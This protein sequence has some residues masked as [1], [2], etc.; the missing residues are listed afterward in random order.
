MT[1]S[2]P[3]AAKFSYELEKGPVW[4]TSFGFFPEDVR[5]ARL[6]SPPIHIHHMH[7]TSTETGLDWTQKNKEG[8]WATEFDIHGDRQ[9][10]REHGGVH[11]L[12]R[13]FPP[14]FGMHLSDPMETFFDL[15]DVR[16]EG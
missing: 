15:N 10:S 9:C 3:Q 8:Q 4:I 14:G 6:G 13:A 7:V 2:C 12:N 5:G 16:L 1:C 11:C